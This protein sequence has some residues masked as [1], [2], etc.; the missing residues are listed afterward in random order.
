MTISLIWAQASNGCLGRDGGL[1]W[2]LPEDL[3]H[4]RSTTLGSTVVMGRRTYASLPDAVRPLPGR[5]TVVL[6]S[7]RVDDPGVR[8]FASV[9]ALLA[10]HTDLWVAGGAQVYAALEPFAER[11]VVTEIDCAFE[12]DVLAPSLGPDWTQREAG[13]WQVST[14]GLTYRVVEHVRPAR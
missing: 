1:P 13:D 10:T 14:T 5:D 2:H 11:A 4:F 8:T 9:E 7:G 12:G 6:T 3:R